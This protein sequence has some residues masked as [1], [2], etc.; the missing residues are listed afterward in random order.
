MYSAVLPTTGAVNAQNT[1][2][3]W[4]L[5]RPV[6]EDPQR[7]FGACAAEY[8]TTAPPSANNM[9]HQFAFMVEARTPFP[10]ASGV[11]F[12]DTDAVTACAASRLKCRS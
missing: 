6:L 5:R 9:E 12:A 10:H 7:R 3:L 2:Q 1:P 4:E 8:P 11:E